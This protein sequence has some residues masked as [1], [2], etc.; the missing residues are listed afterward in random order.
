MIIIKYLSGEESG[1]VASTV[2]SLRIVKGECTVFVG[3]K[4]H[5][6]HSFS[7]IKGYVN[8]VSA[9]HYHELVKELKAL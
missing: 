3:S 9:D 8:E 7:A 6:F 5:N 1:I 4:K 2:E